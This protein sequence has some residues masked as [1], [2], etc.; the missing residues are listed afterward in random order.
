MSNISDEF[1]DEQQFFDKY[2]G[3][4]KNRIGPV[5][6]VL[7]GLIIVV[8]IIIIYALIYLFS[9]TSREFI[10]NNEIINLDALIDLNI[11]TTECCVLQGSGST[12]EEYIHDTANNITYTRTQP[13]DIN[14]VCASFPVPATC[15]SE[16]TDS[17][18]N[19][20]PVATFKGIPY[21]TFENSL[22]VGCS[23][24]TSCQ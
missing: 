24:T 9:G 2:L 20:I 6:I 5:N 18:G 23:S 1:L 12:T 10:E 22:F 4:K 13:T 8:I 17:E 3:I 14:T 7:I 21:Y 15:V 19:I 16:N 11:A